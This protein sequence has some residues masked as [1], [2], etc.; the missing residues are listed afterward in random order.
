VLKDEGGLIFPIGFAYYTTKLEAPLTGERETDPVVLQQGLSKVRQRRWLLWATILIYIPG[1]LIML[2]MQASSGTMGKMFALWIAL[3]C[4][5]IGL[6]TVVK[7]PRCNNTYH[8]NG[9]TFLPVRKCVHC[10][11]P[12]NADKS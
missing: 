1:L 10:G 9:P 2:D 5:S 6:A 3:I 7:C 11:L 8:T 4:V 12:L